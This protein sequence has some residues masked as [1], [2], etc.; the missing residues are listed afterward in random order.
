MAPAPLGQALMR[1]TP[2]LQHTE[3][4]EREP[5]IS[6]YSPVSK[7]LR[8]S[9]ILQRSDNDHGGP[10]EDA[11]DHSGLAPIPHHQPCTQVVSS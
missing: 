5:I 6:S 2:V 3:I 1:D 9:F 10:D 7:S 4:Q 11:P 8:Q